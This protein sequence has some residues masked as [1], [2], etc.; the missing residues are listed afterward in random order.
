MLQPFL[1]SVLATAQGGPVHAELHPANSDVYLEL[2]DV[3]VLL[4]E[5]DKAPLL[6]FLRDER[7]AGLL[8]EVGQSPNR[9]LKELAKEGL[10]RALPKASAEGWLDGLHAI[11]ASVVALGP[12]SDTTA[13]VAFLAVADFATAEQ[14]VALR[15][16]LVERAPKHEAMKTALPGVE[17]LHMGDTAAEDLWCVAVGP[18]LVVGGAAS[19]VEDY[20]ARTEKKGASLASSDVFRK[21]LAALDKPSGTLV[22][23]FALARSIQD[24]FKVMQEKDDAGMDFLSQLPNDLNPLGGAR[25]AR[26]QFVGE[27]FLT[28]MV[29]SDA[30]GTPA[31]PPIDPAWLEPVPAGSM[32]VYSSAFDGAAAGKRMRALLAKDEQSAAAMSALEQKLGFGPERVLSR[33]GP[34]MTAYAAPPAGIGLPETRVWIDCDDPAAFTSDFEALVAALG[35]TLPGFLVKTK[36]YKVKKSGTD[37]KIEVPITTL[38]LPPDLVQI[39]MIQLSP[40]FAPVGK[41]LVFGFSSM[42]VKNELKRVHAG[43]GEPIVAGAHPLSAYGFQ[44]PAEARS[45]FI[46]DWG[47]LLASIIGTVKAFAGMAGPEAMPFDLA[48]LPPPEMFGQYFKPTIHYTKSTAGGLYRRNEASF[49]PETWLGIFAAAATSMA[50]QSSSFGSAEPAGEVAPPEPAGGGQ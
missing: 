45:V 11:S 41:K 43:E 47:K 28:E 31:S 49:G 6:R 37:E 16:A 42:D 10:A 20:V 30:A 38:T 4:T 5:L 29:S 27:R 19:K 9:P 33:L 48:K 50:R 3:S 34:G 22:L 32:I 1:L 25:V 13:P 15:S 12:G 21:Q 17:C 14:A 44:L 39:P 7:L 18:R 36:P 2:A 40:S 35:E 24:I 26:M 23:W 46:M 8:T